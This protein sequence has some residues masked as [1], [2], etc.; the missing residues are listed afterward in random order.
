MGFFLKI[1]TY[2]RIYIQV[3]ID[4]KY[5][6]PFIC[7]IIINIDY[8][9]FFKINVCAC[10]RA[11]VRAR[12]RLCVCVC[13]GDLTGLILPPLVLLRQVKLCLPLYDGD[14]TDVRIMLK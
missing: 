2:A 6:T 13:G 7:L 11:S 10:V 3:H 9:C 1:E 14:V 12:V 5:Y 8:I 4:S